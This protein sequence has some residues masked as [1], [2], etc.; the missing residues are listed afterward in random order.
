MS[1]YAILETIRASGDDQ[2]NEIETRTYA[3]CNQILSSARLEAKQAKAEAIAEAVAP[4]YRQQA[5]ITQR[6]RLKALQILGD[7]R[8]EFVDLALR[9][10]NNCLVDIRAETNYP[11]ILSLLIEEALAELK[12]SLMAAGVIQLEADPRDRV[13]LE[14]ILGEMQQ[15]LSVRYVLDCWGG[16][17]AKSEDGRVVVINTMEAR[18]ERATPHLRRYLAA[19]FEHEEPE[20][21]ESQIAERQSVAI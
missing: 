4:A 2:V 1:L 6:A 11:Q 9:Q 15:E 19:L 16:L 8:E 12:G 3:Q 17:V 7:A 18:L 21:E 14:G 13:L 5:R 10:L 20:V